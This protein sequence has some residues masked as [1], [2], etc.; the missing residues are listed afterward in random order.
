[1]A[2]KKTSFANACKN[3]STQLALAAN[4]IDDLIGIYFDRGY[5]SGGAN[6]IVDADLT[7]Q[8]V[9]AADVTAF[10]TMAQQ[11]NNFLDNASVTEGDYDATLNK[12]R[13]DK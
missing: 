5:N 2:T 6:E 10:I 8:N 3:V 7:D 1:M 9:S 13:T 4:E 11:F 12:L